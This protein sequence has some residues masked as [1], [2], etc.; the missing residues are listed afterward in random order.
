MYQSPQQL[1]I[2]VFYKLAGA[3]SVATEEATKQA[4]KMFAKTKAAP[5]LV[6]AAKAAKKAPTT[7]VKVG[8]LSERLKQMN[9]AAGHLGSISAEAMKKIPKGVNAP[10]FLRSAASKSS[11]SASASS[12]KPAQGALR[13]I[14]SKLK[15]SA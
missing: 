10:E 15:P 11:S 9:K 13:S 4:P 8:P 6:E 2:N 1:A 3:W 14:L 12:A 5:T 7:P